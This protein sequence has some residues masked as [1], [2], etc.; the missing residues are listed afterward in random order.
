MLGFNGPD[1]LDLFGEASLSDYNPDFEYGL[2]PHIFCVD[3]RVPFENPVF[4]RSVDVF[5]PATDA[6]GQISVS[7]ITVSNHARELKRKN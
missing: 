6:F 7:C 5:N 1:S 3:N 2:V 4:V